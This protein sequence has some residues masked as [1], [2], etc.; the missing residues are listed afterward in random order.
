VEEIMGKQVGKQVAL[1]GG[2]FDPVHMGHLKVA[3][4]IYDELHFEKIVFLPAAIPPHKVGRDCA[5]ATDRL[6]MLRLALAKYPYFRLDEMEIK[7]GGLSYTFETISAIR[8]KHPN[9]DVYFLIGADS[10]VQLDTWYHSKELIDEVKFVVAKRPGYKP[11][12]EKLEYQFGPGFMDK[13]IFVNTVSMNISSTKI[14]ERVRQGKKIT[15]LV[16]PE[17][18]QYILEHQLYK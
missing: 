7:K 5:S 8:K 10:L 18:E 14:R 15:G 17:V 9:D 16:T 3:Q 2:T 1:M 6:A 4:C 12:M 11:D 13:L